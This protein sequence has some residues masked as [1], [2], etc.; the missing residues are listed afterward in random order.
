MI[1]EK[2]VLI[3]DISKQD[4]EFLE[5]LDLKIISINEPISE[6]NKKWML[7]HWRI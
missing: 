2:D 6:D 4:K 5:T 1:D 7:Y 3:N